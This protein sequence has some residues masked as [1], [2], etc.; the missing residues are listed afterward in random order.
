MTGWGT[1]LEYDFSSRNIKTGYCETFGL[2][3]VLA[4]TDG[5]L[6]WVK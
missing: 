2:F 4:V 3:R 6:K 1:N 5:T